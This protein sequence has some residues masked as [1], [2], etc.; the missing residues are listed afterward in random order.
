MCFLK[1][2]LQ[3]HLNSIAAVHASKLVRCQKMS[4]RST[5]FQNEASPHVWISGFGITMSFDCVH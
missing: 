1:R 2:A 3:M 5:D 4:K